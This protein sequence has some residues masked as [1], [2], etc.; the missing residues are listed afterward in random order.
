MPL[1]LA[2]TFAQVPP[3]IAGGEA[4]ADWPAVVALLAYSASAGYDNFCSGTLIGPREVLTCAHCVLRMREYLDGGADAY[5]IFGPDV[6]SGKE[7]FRGVDAWRSHEGYTGDTQTDVEAD[8]DIGVLHLDTPVTNVEPVEMNAAPVDDT[9]VGVELDFVGY[10]RTAYET[11]DAGYK[12]HTTMP[13]AEVGETWVANEVPGQNI[14]SGDSGSAALRTFE[15]GVTRIVGVPEAAFWRDGQD[16]CATGG[17]WSLRVDARKELV[18]SWVAEMAADAQPPDTDTGAGEPDDDEEVAAGCGCA[19][20]PLELGGT[21]VAI[22]MAAASA[23]R[24]RG[25]I[26]A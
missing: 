14:C 25:R 21:W 23:R 10:G 24:G 6:W 12:R 11:N 5:V 4:T 2:P 22:A 20:G 16:P 19:A 7:D 1:L 15:D 9:W 18:E 8:T 26:S 3:P 17:G 13:I